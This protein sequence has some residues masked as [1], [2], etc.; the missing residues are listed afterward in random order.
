M[1]GFNVKTQLR[2]RFAETDAQ[3][4]VSNVSYMTYLEVARIEF[5]RAAGIS[6]KDRLKFGIDFVLVEACIQF[7]SAAVADDLLTIHVGL[8]ELK[9]R[10]FTLDYVITN[11]GDHDRVVATAHTVTVAINPATMKACMI[12]DNVREMFQ[13]CGKI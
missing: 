1:E 13:S 9:D 12:P 5:L 7:K 8:K 10:A 3:G 4:I 2:V 11:D 6:V